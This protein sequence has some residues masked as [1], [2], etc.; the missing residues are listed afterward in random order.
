MSMLCRAAEVSR[1]GYYRYL[2]GAV[3]R[4]GEMELRDAIQRIA[5]GMPAYGYRRVTRS[6]RRAGWRVNHKRVLRLM[7]EDNLLCLRRRRFVRTTDSDHG[8][9]IYP[10]LARGLKLNGS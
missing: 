10:N 3:S 1:S 2:K 5:I 8:E 7:R 4:A 6:L 9:P